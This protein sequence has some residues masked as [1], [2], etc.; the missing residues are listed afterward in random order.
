M[1]KS[2]RPLQCYIAGYTNS[3][4][5]PFL[6]KHG[7]GRGLIVFAIPGLGVLF[8]CRARGSR[9]D[10]EFGAYFALLRFITVKLNRERIRN[11]VVFSSCPEFVFSFSGP[12]RFIKEGSE[13]DRLL[14]EYR[15]KLQAVV[16]YLEP[17]KN[18]GLASSADFPSIPSNVEGAYAPP[19]RK[20]EKIRFEPFQKG[21]RL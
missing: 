17:H 12:S 2:E 10:L 19:R 18:P 9:I 8:R 13:R 20:D 21:L 3:K 7:F 6:E 14:G 5:D 4:L 11:V 1:D 15:A 16:S